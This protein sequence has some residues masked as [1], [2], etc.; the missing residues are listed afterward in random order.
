MAD[1]G[2]TRMRRYRAKLRGGPAR[3]LKPCGTP[4]ARKRHRRNDDEDC[5]ICY[6]V[7]SLA[8][9]HRARRLEER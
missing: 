2:A 6:P 5:P 1:D 9:R 7:G 3:S 8:R 4:A